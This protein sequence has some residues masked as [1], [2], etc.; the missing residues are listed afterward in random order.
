[1]HSFWRNKNIQHLLN[2][3]WYILILCIC[4]LKQQGCIIISHNRNLISCPSS[5]PFTNYPE[6]VAGS[7][8][9]PETYWWEDY[10][11]TS[12]GYFSPSSLSHQ[13]N[14]TLGGLVA[15]YIENKYKFNNCIPKL[16][17]GLL[18]LVNE[19]RILSAHS[20]KKE[21]TKINADAIFNLVIVFLLGPE[22]WP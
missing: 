4:P 2:L 13:M 5:Y 15:L 10:L 3:N 14:F 21:I 19:Y 6:D 11:I 12:F 18:K 1:M 9:I 22:C 8:K 16:H 20:K 7:D 17:D